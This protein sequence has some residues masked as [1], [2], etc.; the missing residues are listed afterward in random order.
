MLNLWRRLIGKCSLTFKLSLGILG[1]VMLGVV[2]LLS[3]VSKNSEEIIFNQ[4]VSSAERSIHRASSSLRETAI[5]VEQAVTAIRNSL[6]KMPSTNAEV[7]HVM[8]QS[9]IETL[10]YEGSGLANVWIYNFENDNVKTGVLYSGEL[11]DGEFKFKKTIISDLYKS[12]PW[13]KEVPKKEELYWSEPYIDVEDDNKPLVVTCLIPF[14]FKGAKYFNGLVAVSVDLTAIQQEIADFQFEETGRLLLL[15]REGRYI[16]H[17]DPKI[18]MKKTIFDLAEENGLPQFSRAGH[19][20]A[21]GE[22]GYIEMPDS[23]VYGNSVIFFYAPIEYLR[24]GMCL[25]FSQ[26]KFFEPIHDFQVKVSIALLFSMLI[27]FG[28]I[29]FICHWSTRSLLNLSKVAEQ[30][31][32]GNFS[33]SLPEVYTSDEIGVMSKAFHTMRDNLVDLLENEKRI[34]TEQQKNQSELEIAS[35][36]QLSALP[37]DF[38]ANPYFEICASM[39]SAQRVGGD[40]YD[41]F[42]TD[43]NHFCVLIADVAGKGIP[44]SLYMMTAKTMLKNAILYDTSLERACFGV[45]K[46][47]CAGNSD[48]N[49]FLTAFVAI[50]NIKTGECEY[51]NAGHNPPFI[52]KNGQYE[53]LDVNK[54]TILGG[55]EDFKYKSQFIT[56]KEGERLFLYTDGVTEAQNKKGNFYGEG[57]LFKIL[58]KEPLHSAADTLSL[59]KNDIKKYSAG[60][61]QSDDIT[62]LEFVFNGS[63][64]NF[65]TVEAKVP[66]TPKVLDYIEQGMKQAGVSRSLQSKIM[67]A[68]EE[69]FVNIAMYAYDVGGYARISTIVN[70]NVFVVTFM[71]RGRPYNP[72]EREDPDITLSAEQRNIGGLGVFM[73][74]KVSDAVNYSYENGQNILQ[75]AFKID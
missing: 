44:A 66:E 52:Y 27:L 33:A 12:F 9:T 65:F 36:I 55:I 39:N 18:E 49:A 68:A 60:A 70:D 72:L 56:L 31:G 67:I 57:R 62:M 61:I 3:F 7:V 14:K 32:K 54:N 63:A 59:V 20:M 1:G 6:S 34:I 25:V 28:I 13:F 73:I 10:N 35:N 26:K 8:I 53:K 41:F 4:I 15:S 64:H 40:F 30:Y 58:N 23:T 51:V 37:V 50:I 74:K 17:P 69:I 5:E 11:V 22:R 45:N 42:F 21:M 29:R 46:E 43:K 47:L 19:K 2:V 16:V 38:P 48:T 71:D 75:I 24:W